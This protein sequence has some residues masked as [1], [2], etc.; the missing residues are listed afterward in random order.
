MRNNSHNILKDYFQMSITDE[1]KRKLLSDLTSLNNPVITDLF[2]E[3]I[4]KCFYIRDNS[5]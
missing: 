4:S 2:S 3:H 1:L 5:P